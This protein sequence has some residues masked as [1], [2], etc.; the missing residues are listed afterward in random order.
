[1]ETIEETL[2]RLLDFLNMFEK[3]GEEVIASILREI[4][5]ILNYFE[6]RIKKLEKPGR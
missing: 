2:K 4:L 6:S 5:N 1:M 3:P